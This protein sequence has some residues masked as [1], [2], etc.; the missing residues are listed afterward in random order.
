MT[1]CTIY[2]TQIIHQLEVNQNNTKL[3][4]YFRGDPGFLDCDDI[5]MRVVN[6][7]LELL[8]FVFNSVYVDLK[9]NEF[10]ITFIAVSMCLC[11]L[12]SH[13]VVLALSVR[14]FRYPMW[15]RWLK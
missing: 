10:S 3:H 5:C 15:V 9:Y 14:L 8:E 2:S 11:G 13:V 7:H 1:L 6:K 12:C 4:Q